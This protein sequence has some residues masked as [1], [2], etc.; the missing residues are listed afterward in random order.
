MRRVLLALAMKAV[1]VFMA[2]G[3]ASAI[4]YGQPGGNKHTNV[5]AL[6]GTCDGQ[7]YPYC[8]GTLISPDRLPDGRALRGRRLDCLRHLRLDLHFEVQALHRH[9]PLERAIPGLPG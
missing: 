1:A 7:Q 5:G 6:I 3:V 2:A 4:T 8:S 9:V